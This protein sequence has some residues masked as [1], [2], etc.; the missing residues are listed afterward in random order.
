MERADLYKI[1]INSFRETVEQYKNKFDLCKKILKNR[2]S[3]SESA[4]GGKSYFYIFFLQIFYEKVDFCK[5]NKNETCPIFI[6]G[7]YL[8]KKLSHITKD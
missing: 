1:E 5:G 6:K 4:R 7:K 2:S 3:D 8:N